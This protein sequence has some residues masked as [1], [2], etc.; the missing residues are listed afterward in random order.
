MALSSARV[1][2]PA[3]RTRQ[4]SFGDTA[5]EKCRSLGA[6]RVRTCCGDAIKTA[7]ARP[8][9]GL[10]W[11]AYSRGQSHAM[12]IH[13]S[14]FAREQ[15][16]P[17]SRRSAPL[18]TSRSAEPDDFCCFSLTHSHAQLSSQADGYNL[19]QNNGRAAGQVVII[20]VPSVSCFSLAS[21]LY[22]FQILLLSS[23]PPCSAPFVGV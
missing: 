23:R 2:N 8:H 15:V 4:R 18:Y 10:G 7:R 17:L 22:P 5:D 13:K 12:C 3:V 11:R 21:F 14:G 16:K 9:V 20:I 1:A 19:V 6:V